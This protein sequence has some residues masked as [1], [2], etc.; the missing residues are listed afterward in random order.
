MTVLVRGRRPPSG[1]SPL[2]FCGLASQASHIAAKAA[3]ASSLEAL[4]PEGKVSAGLRRPPQPHPGS[5]GLCPS[6]PTEGPGV[7]RGRHQEVAE[8]RGHKRNELSCTPTPLVRLCRGVKQSGRGMPL[9]P[10]PADSHG[11]GAF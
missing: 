8:L 2:W 4:R 5:G 7:C 6:A 10:F 1:A 9:S 11:L 3:P